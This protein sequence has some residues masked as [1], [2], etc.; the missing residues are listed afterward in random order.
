MN[1][2]NAQIGSIEF[3]ITPL[4]MDRVHIFHP[5]YGLA[6]YL[7]E[8]IQNLSGVW[9]Q[10]ANPA[11]GASAKLSVRTRQESRRLHEPP[12]QRGAEAPPVG[13]RDPVGFA[14]DGNTVVF[15]SRRQ[16][17]IKRSRVAMFATFGYITLEIWGNFPS[18]LFL[19]VLAFI[20]TFHEDG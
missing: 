9:Q 6:E 3:F 10:E 5:I 17:E 1:V 8:N 19:S 2:P 4:V 20:R 14:S 13:S 18:Y 11:P 15:S 7:D 12:C 16:M